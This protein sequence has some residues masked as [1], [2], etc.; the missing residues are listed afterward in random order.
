MAAMHPAQA[1]SLRGALDAYLE[2][3]EPDR[4]GSLQRSRETAENLRA[5]GY[6]D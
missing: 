2:R 3:V 6:I 4:A 5:L 1:E